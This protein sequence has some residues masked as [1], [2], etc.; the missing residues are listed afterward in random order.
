MLTVSLIASA[1]VPLALLLLVFLALRLQRTVDR[2]HEALSDACD[3][4]ERALSSALDTRLD[5]QP[6]FYPQLAAVAES[7]ERMHSTLRRMKTS[8]D[9]S[10]VSS[11]SSSGPRR[12][13]SATRGRSRTFTHEEM[14]ELVRRALGGDS[15][16]AQQFEQTFAQHN[17]QNV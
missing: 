3:R 10:S 6:A 8:D 2:K 17:E 7:V 1:A 13:S 4:I 15:L 16:E 5:K 9:S 11:S 12:I 14:R